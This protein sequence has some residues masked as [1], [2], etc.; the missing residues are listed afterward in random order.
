MPGSP[1]PVSGGGTGQVGVVDGFSSS[2]ALCHNR[3]PVLLPCVSPAAMPFIPVDDFLSLDEWQALVLMLD[4]S[5][6]AV[7][8]ALPVALIPAFVLARFRFLGRAILDTVV[9]LPL[10]LPPVVVGWLLPP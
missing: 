7:A 4:V 8:L 3:G 5:V 6:R 2:R 10:V 9:H 1:P